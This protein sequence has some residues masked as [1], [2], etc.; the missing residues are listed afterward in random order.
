M[1]KQRYIQDSFWTDPYVETLKTK[2]KLLF[3]YYLTN[4]L[5][6]IAGTY[7]IRDSRVSYETQ[8]TEEDIKIIKK[9]FVK[10]G[11]ILIYD[12]WIIF[13]KSFRFISKKNH[14]F[15]RT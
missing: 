1:S 4:P 9:K 6:N 13:I 8:I 11:K 2:E 5:C 7:E 10:D 12:D 15:R 14:R 3:I